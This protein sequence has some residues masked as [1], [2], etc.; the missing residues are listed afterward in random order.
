ML[1]VYSLSL[2]QISLLS[3]G[4]EAGPLAMKFTRRGVINILEGS[5]PKMTGQ[6]IRP[7]LLQVKHPLHVHTPT[8]SRERGHCYKTQDI[9]KNREAVGKTTTDVSTLITRLYRA[10][11]SDHMGVTSISDVSQRSSKSAVSSGQ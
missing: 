3:A 5:H 7:P 4:R 11:V 9:C 2:I 1:L 6:H 8:C 10:F